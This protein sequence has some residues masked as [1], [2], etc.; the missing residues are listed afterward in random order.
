MNCEFA[1]DN[2]VLYLY[3]ELPDDVRHEFEHHTASCNVCAAE[4]RDVRA[5]K[6]DVAAQSVLEPTPNLLAACRVRL[7]EALETTEPTP[8]WRRTFDPVDWLQQMK[9]APALASAILILGFFGGVLTTFATGNRQ[10]P[11]VIGEKHRDF[12]D[13]F[14]VC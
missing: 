10:L 4:L 8:W 7:S 5:L 11:V 6:G 14:H 2:V 9:F 12:F 13:C 1:K 3:D